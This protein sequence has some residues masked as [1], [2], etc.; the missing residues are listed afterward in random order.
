MVPNGLSLCKIHLAAF[1]ANVM[2]VRPYLV[3]AVRRDILKEHDGPMLTY[4]LQASRGNNWS[5]PVNAPP[6]RTLHA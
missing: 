2:G 6:A 1:D 4:G 3:I 5:S